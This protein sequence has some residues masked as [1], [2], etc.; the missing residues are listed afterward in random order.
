[1]VK[2]ETVVNPKDAHRMLQ[3][4]FSQM[5]PQEFHDRRSK[6]AGEEISTT[7]QID[8][9]ERD[10][11]LIL[12]QREPAPLRLSGYLATALTS[13]DT[14]QMSS[15]IAVSDIILSVCDALDIEL[16]EPRKHTDPVQHPD[17]AASEVYT[18]DRERVLGSDLLIHLGDYASTGAGEELE[19]AQTALVPII[20]IA[21]GE[22]RVSRMV[23]G[24]PVLKLIITYSR[25][26]EL[27]EELRLRLLEI[28]P[29]LEERKL[30][31]AEFDK[32][33]VGNKIRILREDLLLTRED[34][35]SNSDQLFSVTRLKEI[36]QSTDKISNPSL[37][38]MRALAAI[39]KSTVADLVAPDLGERVI[40]V[41]QEW[42]RGNIAA[43]FTMSENDERKVLRR[44]L[45]RVCD[46]LEDE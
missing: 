44:I 34:V 27:Q 42:M 39:L 38:E 30:A 25:L 3:Q 1:M 16:Y 2:E 36:E 21:H 12:Y 28:R 5:A 29:I 23:T 35:A 4:H 11:K 43:R 8:S 22:S 40:V 45:Y 32:N 13:L 14:D 31:F 10:E 18:Q 37:L 7:D 24:I 17:V 26:S 41:L 15:L 9:V 19:I 6:Y 33:L 46:S 20:V